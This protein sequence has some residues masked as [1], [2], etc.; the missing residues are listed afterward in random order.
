MVISN[1]KDA[2]RVDHVKFVSYTGKYPNLCSGNLTLLI[3]GETVKFDSI[4]D[5]FW[6]S[7]GF[8]SDDYEDVYTEEWI[9]C[10]D[11]LPEKY[12]KYAYEIDRVFNAHVPHGC[13]G[14]CIKYERRLK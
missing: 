2:S 6:E 1:S 10:I 4:K 9:I 8:I 14:G 11:D 3:D 13:C 7:G 5:R 12:R